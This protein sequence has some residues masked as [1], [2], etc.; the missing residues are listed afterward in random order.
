MQLA[1]AKACHEHDS[2]SKARTNTHAAS[3]AACRT[4]AMAIAHPCPGLDHHLI[5]RADAQEPGRHIAASKEVQE[6]REVMAQ[7]V[8]SIMTCMLQVQI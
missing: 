4:M 1:L 8:S 5:I 2:L 7:Y 6:S 3:M